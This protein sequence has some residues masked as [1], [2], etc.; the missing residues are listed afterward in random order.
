MML[1]FRGN[2]DYCL[3]G[4]R[5]EVRTI[6]E[7]EEGEEVIFYAVIFLYEVNWIEVY[8]PLD[9]QPRVGPFWDTDRKTGI[10]GCEATEMSLL[11]H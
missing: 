10:Y 9:R 5:M 6:R 7:I 3:A 1:M 4:G 8:G 2:A 11:G